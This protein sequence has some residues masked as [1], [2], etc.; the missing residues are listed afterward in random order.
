MLKLGPA[1]TVTT[2]ERELLRQMFTTGGLLGKSITGKQSN[3]HKEKEARPQLDP[4]TVNAVVSEYY[5]F[6]V[7]GMESDQ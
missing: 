3:V 2:Y 6:V 5:F 1:K 7:L 4:I